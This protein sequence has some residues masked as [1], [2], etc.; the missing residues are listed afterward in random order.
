MIESLPETTAPEASAR[1]AALQVQDVVK[2]FG[3]VTAVAGVSFA[4]GRGELVSLLGASGCGKSTLL[5][6]IAG[7]E[8]LDAGRISIGGRVASD[9]ERRVALPPERRGLGMVF[10]SYALWPHMTVQANVEYPLRC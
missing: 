6:M 7:I 10:Q 2:R 3:G 1:E 8:R 5:R 4:V 9:A